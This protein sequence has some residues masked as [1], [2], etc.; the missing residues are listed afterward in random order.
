VSIKQIVLSFFLIVSVLLL[1]FSTVVLAVP[2]ASGIF[3]QNQ[4]MNSTNTPISPS[5]DQNKIKSSNIQYSNE[6]RTTK[7]GI[8]IITNRPNYIIGQQIQIFLWVFDE[9]LIHRK[10][11]VNVQALRGTELIYN[12]TVLLDKNVRQTI[13]GPNTDSEGIYK[14]IAKTRQNAGQQTAS[15]T[16]KVTDL[17]KSVPA[18]FVY[19]AIVFVLGLVILILIPPKSHSTVEIFR[20]IC[21]TG[22]VL[23]A[24][25]S[26]LL[27]DLQIGYNSPVGLVISSTSNQTATSN[28][29]EWALNIGGSPINNFSQGILIPIYV[30]VLG[31]V[32]GY[33]RYLYKSARLKTINSPLREILLFRWDNVPGTDSNTLRSFL[34]ERF[35]I[36]WL[37][38]QEFKKSNNNQLL[39]IETGSNLLKI[40]LNQDTQSAKA[41]IDNMEIYRFS[42]RE[43]NGI[44]IYQS[45]SWRSWLFYQSLEDLSLLFLAPLLAIAVWFLLVQAGISSNLTLA[46]SSFTVGLV[47]DEVIRALLNFIRRTLGTVEQ[48]K[49]EAEPAQ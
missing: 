23:S 6:T 16:I 19:L 28:I 31:L 48:G 46:L 17:F 45:L 15:I 20:F 2:D 47:T 34:K 36:K 32:G 14:I 39:T 12:T 5:N 7:P 49:R 13:S 9:E 21:I 37:V 4:S 3:Y 33:L 41:S 18:F 27:T 40:E 30:V 1:P 11:N 24:L 44:N 29:V 25:S 42:A 35:D 26:L 10:A 8:Y 38:S 43:E 22:I